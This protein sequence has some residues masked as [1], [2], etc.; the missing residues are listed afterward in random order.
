MKRI[1]KRIFGAGPKIRFGGGAALAQAS[2]AGPGT[3]GTHFSAEFKDSVNAGVPVAGTFRR[4]R[5]K[6][7]GDLY[8]DVD[9]A[10]QVAGKDGEVVDVVLRR[11]DH[12]VDRLIMAGLHAQH[13][14]CDLELRAPHLSADERCREGDRVHD[15]PSLTRAG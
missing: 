7:G 2:A 8:A 1:F 9:V 5:G 4:N 14:A 15:V 10:A 3:P 12:G 11:L 6:R 13:L